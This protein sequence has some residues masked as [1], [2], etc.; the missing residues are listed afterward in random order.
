MRVSEDRLNR[1]DVC[2]VTNEEAYVLIKEK[3]ELLI[4]DVSLDE[5]YEKCHIK[6][7]VSIPYRSIRDN[8]NDL[9]EY[10]EKDMLVY[11]KTGRGSMVAVT[12]LVCKGF[13]NIYHMYQGFSNWNYENVILGAEESLDNEELYLNA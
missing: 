12:V 8:I 13:K 2:N 11:C 4:L 6:N 5:D 7:A 9:Q 1:K 10:K 3:P